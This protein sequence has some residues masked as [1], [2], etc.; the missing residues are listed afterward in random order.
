LTFEIGYGIITL[1]QSN[2]HL[3]LLSREAEGPARR[4]LGNQP[5]HRYGA[6]SGR[7]N[8]WK[9]RGSRV[10]RPPL[11]DK[12]R[13]FILS[14]QAGTRREEKSFVFFVDNF[15]APGQKGKIYGAQYC[16]F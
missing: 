1:D 2:S 4:S 15:I 13:R 7:G 14:Q 6:N 11:L 3:T 8:F 5:A 9:M 12:E 10:V 16:G